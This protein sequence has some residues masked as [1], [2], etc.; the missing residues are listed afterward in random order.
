MATCKK[1]GFT[2]L[3]WR[4]HYGRWS[5]YDLMA[6]R[7][8]EDFCQMSKEE[9]GRLRRQK[10]CRHGVSEEKYCVQCHEEKWRG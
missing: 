8:H 4:Q 1:C 7:W 10:K 9:Y 5:L 3:K 6:K 2:D